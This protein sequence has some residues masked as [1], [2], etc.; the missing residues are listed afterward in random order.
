MRPIEQHISN[1]SRIGS[2]IWPHGYAST[3]RPF[4]EAGSIHKFLLSSEPKLCFEYL[5]T[6]G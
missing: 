3:V 1:G 4:A 5:L 6:Y 2:S